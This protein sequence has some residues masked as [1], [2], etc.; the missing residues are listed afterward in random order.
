MVNSIARRLPLLALAALLGA[1]IGPRRETGSDDGDGSPRSSA[2]SAAPSAPSSAPSAPRARVGI[3][4]R[5]T[6][7]AGAPADAPSAPAPAYTPARPAR[8]VEIGPRAADPAAQFSPS[9][10]RAYRPERGRPGPAARY[11]PSGAAA[12]RIQRREG[13]ENVARRHYWHGSDDGRNSRYSDHYY[14][15]HVH[16]YGYPYGE[17]FFWMRPYSGLWW[18]WDSRFGR[19]SYWNDGFWWWPGPAGV[20]YVFVNDNYYPY[21]SVQAAATSPVPAVTG[22]GPGAWSSPDGRR[23]I[24]ITGPD[25]EAALYDKTRETPAYLRFLGRDVR[26]VRFSSGA[27]GG[28][29]TIL[30][31]FRS[32]SFALYD[33]DGR[34]L[35]TAAPATVKAVPPAGETP[36]APP[37]ELPP[38]PQ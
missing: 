27:N 7:S 14:D 1:G 10:A 28:P 18:T 21:G 35:D 5:E 19:W 36:P 32:G 15:G 4:R 13:V 29:P 20:Q 24:E 12:V 30:I 17:S 26:K 2:P 31:D 34:R 25:N 11:S 22:D 23:L 37:D 6:P 33:Y 3:G 38:P 8:R 16:W 9:G